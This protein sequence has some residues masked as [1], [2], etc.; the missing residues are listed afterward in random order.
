VAIPPHLNIT[1]SVINGAPIKTGVPS[2]S[3]SVSVSNDKSDLAISIKALVE[4][5]HVYTQP[6][7]MTRTTFSNPENANASSQQLA[8][9]SFNS[10]FGVTLAG[11]ASR[12]SQLLSDGEKS[13]E[14][15][16]RQYSNFYMGQK[17]NGA[18][19]DIGGFTDI[20]NKK[21]ASLTINLTTKD[22]DTI[23]FSLQG[24]R[25]YGKSEESMGS[26]FKGIKVSFEFEGTLSDKE[27]KEIDAFTQ[28]IDELM[29]QLSSD[30]NLDLGQLNLGSLSTFSEVNL[31]FKP[32]PFGEVTDTQ[33][34]I[35]YSDNDT[36][37]TI[38]VNFLGHKSQLNI[39]KTSLALTATEQ[40]RQQG[41]LQYLS[42]LDSSAQEAHAKDSATNVMKQVFEAGFSN[43][44][45]EE[46]DPKDLNDTQ[47]LHN[48]SLV[49]LPDFNFSFE[50][51]IETP[52]EENRPLEYEGF[53]LNISMATQIEQD[54]D[55]DKVTATQTQ[56]FGLSAAYYT[57]LEGLDAPDFKDQNYN[58]TVLERSSEKV[59]NVES[60]KGEVKS[61]NTLESGENK[62]VGLEYRMGKMVDE[63]IDTNNFLELTDFTELAGIKDETLTQE[64]LN[65]VMID[66]YNIKQTEEKTTSVTLDQ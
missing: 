24:Y 46:K 18:E 3:A 16:I 17:G 45:E 10:H 41:I 56:K 28:N 15:D 49:A 39:D 29:S 65:T 55:S 51:K 66:P 34:E 30:A 21:D 36:D 50:S 62:R 59:T 38:N 6:K 19:I 7:R 13:Y 44:V 58:Y 35:D 52:N 22:G 57:P 26:M 48:R 37:R 4:N 14:Q 5:N 43:L 8:N 11:G 2:N 20:E 25:G 33:L 53:K 64:L 9:N 1:P 42:L 32:S 23:T 47:Q 60:D 40:Q 31:S 61:A 12:L 27:K 54:E 63:D